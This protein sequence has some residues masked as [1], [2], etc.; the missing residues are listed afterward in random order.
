MSVFEAPS[1][2]AA[3]PSEAEQVFTTG[4]A[5][6]AEA[7]ELEGESG[8]L[9]SPFR[10]AVAV[11]ES[12]GVHYEQ[13]K[14]G[15]ASLESPFQSS[16]A[17]VSEAEGTAEAFRELLAELE[18]E[19]FDE[20][21]AQLVDE[22][23]GLHLA[24]GASWSSGEAA[25]AMAMSELET[26]IEPLRQETHRMLD[27]MAERLGNEELETLRD[28]ELEALFESLRPD[29]G[30]MPEAF[31]NFLGGLFKKA[32]SLVSGAIKLAKKGVGTAV[33]LAKQG[34]SGLGGLLSMPIK[35][36]LGKLK[37]LAGTLLRGVLQKAIG[38]LPGSVQPIAR[39]LAARLLGEAEAETLTGA[40]PSLARQFDIHAASLMLAESEAEA[41]NIVMEAE[42]EA[43]QPGSASL[44]ELDDARARLAEQLTELPAG[45]TPVAE[46]EQFLPA[47]LAARPAIRFGLKL[48]GRDKVVKFL[49]DRIAGLIKG[50]VGA[51]AARLLSPPLVDVGLSALGLE[52]EGQAAAVLGGEALASTVEETV[53]HV[54]ELPA[55]A[56]EDTLR[57]EAEIQEAFAE[58]AARNIPAEHLRPDLP[59]LETAGE[60]GVWILMPRAARPRYRYKKYSRV[61]LVPVTRQI[62]RAIA[63]ADGGTV[64]TML[65]DRGVSTWPVNAEVHLYETLPSATHLGHIA[66]FE[67]EGSAPMS[68]A[69]ADLHPLTPEAA[70]LLVREP[71]LGRPLMHDAGHHHHHHVHH[72]GQ[73]R[74]HRD[75]GD[76]P[77][78][79]GSAPATSA[80]VRVD[81]VAAHPA[82][83]PLHRRRPLPGGSRYFRLRLPGQVR[84]PSARPRRRIHVTD[85]LG[86]SP[87]IRVHVKLSEAE[88]QRL[89]ELLQGGSLPAALAWL[90]HRY[91]RV[92]PA[93]VTAH[94]LARGPAL[95]HAPVSQ[96]GA[97]SFALGVTERVT[98]ALSAFVRDRRAQLTAAV[99]S[100]AQ[101]VTLAFTFKLAGRGAPGHRHVPVPEVTVRPGHHDRPH[102]RLRHHSE[103]EG[104]DG[105]YGG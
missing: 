20:A 8:E 47:L 21:V 92:L 93:V 102:T 10:S 68:E 72:P 80:A 54:L 48:I 105:E 42:A 46:L 70:S 28:S 29:T 69:L 101:G 94:M 45:H 49:A 53:N 88:A 36:L 58:A 85:V 59:Q 44:A 67:G 34:V 37:A 11:G 104:R 55:E 73:V 31:E 33:N 65:Q 13:A 87:S 86:P 17:E 56:F 19:Q 38:L 89:A 84:P 60:R 63:T 96:G 52:A 23:A 62:A 30:F 41:E 76:S 5:L 100:P 90:K 12:E 2:E 18:S 32:R 78:A 6:E 27:N 50:L 99:Q 24:S 81:P 64:E 77:G 82:T 22:A 91:E 4:E 16:F 7:G 74:H 14:P 3:W 15:S 43:E 71:G 97:V 57:M 39:K 61:F 9:E 95:L 1:S 66:Q 103:S 79:A 35:F 26:W 40:D 51:D 83:G 75:F 98:Q 25:P